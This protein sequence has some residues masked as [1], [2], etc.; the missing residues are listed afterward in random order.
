M[1]LPT[2]LIM[3]G[4]TS[5]RMRRSRGPAHKAL[6][7]VLG[8]PLLERNVVA[9][10][11]QGFTDIVVAFSA[12][13]P[14]I[15]QYVCGRIR[16]LVVARHGTVRAFEETRPMGTLGAAGCISW[17]SPDLLVVN[18]D[19][20]TSLNL[21][22]LVA[23]QRRNR[24]AL[25]IATHEHRATIPFGKVTVRN[26]RVVQ[27]VEKPTISSQVC[28]GAYVLGA[29]AKECLDGHPIDAHLLVNALLS[30]GKRVSAYKHHAPWVDINDAACVDS[31]EQLIASCPEQFEY[32][33]CPPDNVRASI[34]V[35]SPQGILGCQ[36]NPR[37]AKAP[38]WTLPSVML[39]ARAIETDRPLEHILVADPTWRPYRPR[40][41][42]C[43]DQIEPWSSR[44]I[45]HVAFAVR[46]SNIELPSSLSQ[47]EHRWIP[48]E[49]LEITDGIDPA[50][51]R[52]IA[53]M[54][55]VS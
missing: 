49:S 34:I 42:A 46:L 32:W 10:L 36:M 38:R 3:A 24:A 30:R 19:N 52:S 50:F 51:K 44:L 35:S 8:V 48:V 21:C 13:E 4:G 22:H 12:G 15:R 27:Y 16:E 25:T 33:S 43:F 31:A 53:W 23:Q 45:R 9:L 18:V 26:G 41:V 2:A 1:Q 11:Q 47:A 40:Y 28:S 37:T 14:E 6:V 39:E 5:S 55:M 17:G 7:P 20:L 54:R 29:S